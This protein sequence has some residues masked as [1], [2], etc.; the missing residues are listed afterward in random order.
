[1]R[2]CSQHLS[3]R[4]NCLLFYLCLGLP[5]VLSASDVSYYGV[6]KSIQYQQTNDMAPVPLA[7]NAYAFNAF[8]VANTNN[9][10]TN[11]TVQVGNNTPI[12]LPSTNGVYWLF[13]DLF[14]SQ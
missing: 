3:R 2:T 9:V 14:N 11:A 5:S 1:M 8:V 4:S 7:T 6:V 13:R 12:P 10:V